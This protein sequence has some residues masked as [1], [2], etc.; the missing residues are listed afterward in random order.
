MRFALHHKLALVGAALSSGIALTDAVTYGVTGDWGP[1]SEEAGSTPVLVVGTVLHGLTYLALAQ[2]LVR[3]G[4]RFAGAGR[5]ARATRWL[6]LGSLVVL[7]AA[8][9]TVVP[10]TVAYDVTEGLFYDAS[11]VVSTIA[12]LGLILGSLVLGLA[13]LRNGALGV[14]ARLLSLLLPVFAATLLLGWLAPV[15]A[16]PGYLETVVYVGLA[17]LGAGAGSPQPVA[18]AAIASPTSAV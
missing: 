13:M 5:L 12:F 3:E 4:P 11:G 17:L 18:R 10:V 2:V 16:H 6:L 14:G 1:F 7:A 15:W 8:F 9:V